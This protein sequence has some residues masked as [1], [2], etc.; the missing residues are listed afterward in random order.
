MKT[1]FAIFIAISSASAWA[2]IDDFKTVYANLVA[3]AKIDR[4]SGKEQNIRAFI[5]ERTQ[6]SGHGLVTDKVGNILVK[7]PATGKYVG[8]TLHPIALQSHLDMK[9]ILKNK[10]SDQEARRY[11]ENGIRLTISVDPSTGKDIINT[12]NFL[13]SNG[14]DNGLG[15]AIQLWLMDHPAIE[16]PPL[17]LVFTVDEEEN[18]TGVR[19]FGLPLTAAAMISLDHERIH[20]ICRG[21][22]GV[23]HL[24]VEGKL[25]SEKIPQSRRIIKVS[26]GG[27]SGGHSGFYI[28]QK[29]LNGARAA[30]A[31][32]LEAL[33]L[34][35]EAS[36][37]QAAAGAVN[38]LNV[39][40]GGMDLVVAV[41]ENRSEEIQ[42]RLSDFVEDWV[43]SCSDEKT[44]AGDVSFVSGSAVPYGLPPGHAKILMQSI[45]DAKNGIVNASSDFPHG[46]RTSSNIGYLAIES[47]APFLRGTRIKIGLMA[48]SYD[49]REMRDSNSVNTKI[50][51]RS[52]GNRFLISKAKVT[53]PSYVEPWFDRGSWPLTIAGETLPHY[54]PT[55]ATPL[56]KPNAAKILGP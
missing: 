31:I 14:L 13:S 46:W 4:P 44:G 2:V 6:R 29:L 28:H 26:L 8:R 24:R 9:Q 19:N 1:I 50:L 22:L 52:W 45:L 38:D 51:T 5:S 15:M 11:F 7:L 23:D 54:R 47:H 40:P 35:P 43:A 39:I 25:P 34:C 17:E 10:V 3:I 32:Y 56:E 27:F 53:R 21:C 12:E 55:V 20:E 42:V 33:R 37:V 16:H 49:A 48:R 36:L 18:F 41:P 30:A